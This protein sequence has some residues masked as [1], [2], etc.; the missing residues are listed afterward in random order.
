[1]YIVSRLDTRYCVSSKLTETIY[2]YVF[3]YNI[4]YS[5][6]LKYGGKNEY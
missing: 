1:M 4:F 2:M 5:S 3:D 6:I